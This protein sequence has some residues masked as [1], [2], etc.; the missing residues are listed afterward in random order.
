MSAKKE[1]AEAWR[2]PWM[3]AAAALLLLAVAVTAALGGFGK[4]SAGDGSRLP[5]YAAGTTIQ[6]GAMAI[7]PLKAWRTLREPGT[8]RTDVASRHQ[9]LV[10]R[11][12]VENQIPETISSSHYL[13]QDLLWLQTRDGKVTG[14]VKAERFRRAGE[15]GTASLS[16]DL[17]P[18]L[19][20]TIDM[21]WKLPLDAPLSAPQQWGVLGRAFQAKVTFYGASGWGQQSP[22][23][24]LR[25]PV[26]DR[27]S[28]VLAP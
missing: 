19:P 10:L 5:V 1:L 27:R 17:Q 20:L 14:E 2:N 11:V 4:A 8:T 7:T 18:G 6:T 15:R 12:K 22:V 28:P 13:A 16:A 24:K 9:Y 25:L 26:E 21:V 23:A 3:R